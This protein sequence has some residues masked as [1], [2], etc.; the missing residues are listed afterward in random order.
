MTINR[1]INHFLAA[2]PLRQVENI[3]AFA[4]QAHLAASGT[5][6]R[7]ASRAATALRE[8]SLAPLARSYLPVA[9]KR[10]W[11]GGRVTP[12]RPP[13]SGLIPPLMHLLPLGSG[14]RR[15]AQ[16]ITLCLLSLLVG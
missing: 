4:P 3:A 7:D 9:Y 8:G 12:A 6:H 13:G 11:D 10:K 2:G 16:P 5:I 14:H 1:T 15:A